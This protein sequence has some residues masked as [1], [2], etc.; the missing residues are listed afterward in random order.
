M[1]LRAGDGAVHIIPFSSV[2]TI[3]NTNRGIGNAAISVTVAYQEDVDRVMTVLSEIGGQMREEE[4]FKLQMLG[5]VQIFGV[6][7]VRP[8]GVTITGQIT[9]TDGGR[10][11]VQREFGRRL[12]QRFDA[13]KIALAAPPGATA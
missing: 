10:W 11:P 4:P 12:K 6:D 5:D 1:R 13:E 2:T 3:T 8:W 9:C 7:Q